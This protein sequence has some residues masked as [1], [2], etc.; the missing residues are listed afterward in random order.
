MCM[1]TLALFYFYGD[2]PKEALVITLTLALLV[3]FHLFRKA[4]YRL[5]K[6]ERNDSVKPLCPRP[7]ELTP[8]GAN[9]RSAFVHYDLRRSQMNPANTLISN[10]LK[11]HLN[12]TL[13]L[14]TR[15]SPPP[16]FP[17]KMLWDPFNFLKN[18]TCPAHHVLYLVGLI[19]T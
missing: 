15:L 7:M 3:R 18:A 2:L 13:H 5:Q 12:N 16:A 19:L 14:H 4:R 6:H 10:F 9:T 1:Y 17:P 8:S 11:V